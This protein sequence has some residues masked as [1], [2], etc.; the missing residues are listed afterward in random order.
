M[1]N[2]VGEIKLF[3][4]DFAPRDWVFCDGR[5]LLIKEH[6]GLYS[7]IQT[8]Y[9]GDGKTNFAVP[10]LRGR[11]ALGQGD[12]SP[13][14]KKAG[15]ERVALT[16][17]TLP[18]HTHIANASSRTA[19]DNGG[20]ANGFWGSSASDISYGAAETPTKAYAMNIESTTPTGHGEAHENRIPILAA[21]YII[22][23]GGNFPPRG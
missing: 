7:L 6:E 4:G 20:A 8:T 22:A 9:G 15:V 12:D 3:T 14:G 17:A 23:T 2:Y 16:E 19:N 11:V 5:L 21:T 18:A 1:F 10:D 13:I